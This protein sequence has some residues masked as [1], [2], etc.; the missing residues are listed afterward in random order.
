[1]PF[2]YNSALIIVT[3][4]C[5]FIRQGKDVFDNQILLARDRAAVA[6]KAHNLEVGGSIPSPAPTNKARLNNVQPQI[7]CVFA[8]SL[9]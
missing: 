5:Y 4:E 8:V 3:V 6:C 1:M 2:W 9:I 7:V